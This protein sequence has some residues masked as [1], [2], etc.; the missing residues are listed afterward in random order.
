M[1]NFDIQAYCN[2]ES[3]YSS[4]PNLDQLVIPLAQP[5]SS[6]SIIVC[7][8][9]YR[10]KTIVKWTMNGFVDFE[11]GGLKLCVGVLLPPPLRN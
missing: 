8:Y 6:S 7:S 2:L 10:Y 5:V 9:R 11:C 3:H 4:L 1:S